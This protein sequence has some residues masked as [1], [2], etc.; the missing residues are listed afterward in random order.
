VCG[1]AYHFPYS[2]LGFSAASGFFLQTSY[3]NYI[4]EMK[5]IGNI[6]YV[7]IFVV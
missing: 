7:G 3:S 5:P 2:E 6:Q 1:T 4:A